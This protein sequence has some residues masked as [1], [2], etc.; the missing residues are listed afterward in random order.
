MNAALQILLRI[1][2]FVQRLE[3]DPPSMNNSSELIRSCVLNIVNIEKRWMNIRRAMS[4]STTDLTPLLLKLETQVTE[5]LSL[6]RFSGS[7]QQDSHEWIKNFLEALPTRFCFH[8]ELV[9]TL[10]CKCSRSPCSTQN[11]DSNMNINTG[12]SCK[13]S[14]DRIEYFRDLSIEIPQTFNYSSFS[15]R[16]ALSQH[17]EDEKVELLC[18]KCGGTHAV[19]STRIKKLPPILMIHLKRFHFRNGRIDKLNT[20]IDAPESLDLNI[21]MDDQSCA[22]ASYTLQGILR[23]HGYTAQGGHYTADTRLLKNVDDDKKRWYS[24]DDSRVREG[25][26]GD[27]ERQRHETGY[28]LVY[29]NK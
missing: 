11:I 7:R 4:K 22:D 10:S 20:L 9:Y 25:K 2:G 18:K 29:V 28:V 21:F 17:F 16:T 1:P 24:F 12:S 14:R 15:L 23:H 26:F 5:H 13:Y 27:T 3:I 8:T 6:L 19:K